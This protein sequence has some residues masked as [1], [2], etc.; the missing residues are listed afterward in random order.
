MQESTIHEMFNELMPFSDAS[1]NRL[2]NYRFNLYLF[3]TFE[4]ALMQAVP[5]FH[6]YK[7]GV[8]LEAFATTD[9]EKILAAILKNA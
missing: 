4:F 5:L 3:K 7:N 1:T 2:I 8:L 9:K 6:F